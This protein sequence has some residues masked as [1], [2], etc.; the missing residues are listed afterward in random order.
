MHLSKEDYIYSGCKENI[1]W[2]SLCEIWHVLWQ[3][4]S[5]LLEA[6]C[7]HYTNYVFAH[8]RQS[9]N[10]H[11]LS[12]RV[13]IWHES[14]AR[15]NSWPL[16]IFWPISVFRQLKS[17]LVSQI[18]CTFSTKR[19]SVS[20]KMSYLQSKQ[21]N[22]SDPYIF[23]PLMYHALFT[24]CTVSCVYSRT[25]CELSWGNVKF[26]LAVNAYKHLTRRQ[27]HRQTDTHYIPISIIEY[28]TDKHTNRQT[29]NTY[30]YNSTAR[31]QSIDY[32]I[33]Q[34]ITDKSITF[35]CEA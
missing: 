11:A 8:K 19:Q 17:I 31:L 1:S 26:K 35:Y 18:Y 23:L 21:P 20:Y 24:L 28:I 30:L 16:V 33:I 27:T 14:S 13:Y 12:I 29:H 9:S 10:L 5:T 32:S 6:I 15:N 7:V 3:K 25:A 22:N 2:T 34:Y 4:S